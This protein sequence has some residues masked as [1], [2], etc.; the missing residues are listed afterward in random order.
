MQ[1][2]ATIR[3]ATSVRVMNMKRIPASDTFKT[4]DARLGKTAAAQA[5]DIIQSS[6]AKGDKAGR[7]AGQAAL[8]AALSKMDP[9]KAQ[10]VAATISRSDP[11]TQTVQDPPVFPISMS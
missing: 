7:R 8:W 11:T 10:Q 5:I 3:S 6:V 2:S 4:I 1:Y 9:M